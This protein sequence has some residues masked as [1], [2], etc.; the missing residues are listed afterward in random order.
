M[1]VRDYTTVL[2]LPISQLKHPRH[3]ALLR[4]F[5][6]EIAAPCVAEAIMALIGGAR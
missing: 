2:A 4:A 3:Q 5:A 1:S 6:G